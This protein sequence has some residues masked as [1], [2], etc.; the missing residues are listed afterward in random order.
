MN[1]DFQQETTSLSVEDAADAILSA[2]P[3]QTESE[4]SEEEVEADEGEELEVED[5]QADEEPE[6][7]E[8]E[9]DDQPEELWFE[10]DGEEVSLAQIK[11]WRQGNL[12]TADYTK[13]TQDVAVQ[14]KQVEAEQAEIAKTRQAIEAERAQL[15]NALAT[16]AIDAD[17]EPD[18]VEMAQTKTPQEVLIEQGQWRKRQAEKQQA[19][20][21]FQELQRQQAKDRRANEVQQVVQ[22]RPEWGTD[23]GFAGVMDSI[24]SVAG[25]HG[26][27]EDDL[28]GPQMDHRSLLI[29][30]ELAETKAK[31]AQYEKQTA[32][33]KK[34]VVKAEPRRGPGS[35]PSKNQSVSKAAKAK[36][37]KF[38]KTGKLD[39]AVD[40]ILASLNTD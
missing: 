2:S 4:E 10:I 17:T 20:A 12:R 5:D 39:D 25:P 1:E 6:E 26:I 38:S 37:A 34:R 23:E 8:A 35:R 3:E 32:E 29:L 15:Q 18:W 27:A 9:E 31:L 30:H 21:V 22:K 14:R 16:L 11:E 36:N 40:A 13:K 33:V 7:E 19:A 28:L 24:M